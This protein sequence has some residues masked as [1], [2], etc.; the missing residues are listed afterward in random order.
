MLGKTFIDQVFE[1]RYPLVYS[2]IVHFI[3]YP[4]IEIK[5]TIVSYSIYK[6]YCSLFEK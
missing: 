5:C 6:M 1:E 2:K 4:C 3:Y